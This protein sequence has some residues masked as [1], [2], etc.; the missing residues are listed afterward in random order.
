MSRLKKKTS[1]VRLH[2]HLFR[3]T[4]A[5]NFIVHGLGDVYELSRLLWHSEIRMT[6]KYLQLASYYTVM[7]KRR[8]V[9]YLDSRKK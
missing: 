8:K 1:I 5:T 9:S 6:E 7:E 3:H 4:F 2:A